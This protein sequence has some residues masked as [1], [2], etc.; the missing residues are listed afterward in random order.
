M[1]TGGDEFTVTAVISTYNYAEVL[2]F[3]I[4][5]ALAQSHPPLEVLVIGDG[6]TDNSAEVVAAVGDSRVRFINLTDR[7][8]SQAGPNNEGIRRAAGSVIAYLGHDDLWFPGHLKQV[9]DAVAAGADLVWSRGLIIDVDGSFRVWPPMT[10][11]PGP[12]AGSMAHRRAAAI[13]NGLWWRTP[14]EASLV[15][16]RD[17]FRSAGAKGLVVHDLPRLG[18]VKISSS[19]RKGVYLDRP[20][21]EQETWSLRLRQPDAEAALG[22]AALLAERN[23]QPLAFLVDQPLTWTLKA[24]ART[25]ARMVAGRCWRAAARPW[26]AS[27]TEL[28]RRRLDFVGAPAGPPA[29]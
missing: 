16:D 5:S 27:L 26:T 3:S 13:D 4:A 12:M 8:G 23:D 1:V 15:T 9:V 2:R 19:R 24:V 20:V 10:A 11:G 14:Q 25:L 29:P 17:F 18:Q 7:V 21:H 6:C 28:S 22:L